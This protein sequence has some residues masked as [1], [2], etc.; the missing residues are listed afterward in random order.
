MI[1]A[2]E[3]IEAVLTQPLSPPADVSIALTELA[4]LLYPENNAISRPDAA[5]IA[6]IFERA[7]GLVAGLGAEADGEAMAQ[8]LLAIARYAYV[9]GQPFQGLPAIKRTVD[10]A[11]RLGR[12][13]L[14]CRA[15]SLHGAILMA[16]GDLAGATEVLANALEIAVELGDPLVQAKVFGN[17]GSLLL[18]MA[19]YDD[20]I[21]CTQQALSL[22]DSLPKDNG[23]VTSM[24]GLL[25]TNIA[26]ACIRVEDFERGLRAVRA[27]IQALCDPP[28]LNDILIRVAAEA[29]YVR[30]LLEVDDLPEARDRCKIAKGI[31]QESGLQNAVLIADMAEGVCEVHSGM[32]E[33]G[34][35]R[36]SK[37]LDRARVA[38]GLVLL[39]DALVDLIKANE[40]AG[41]HDVA[42]VYLRELMMHTKEVQQTNALLHHRLHL[43]E[44]EQ[45][46]R[47]AGC[48]D[49]LLQQ[50]EF[51][52]R[53]K[54]V[55]Q[56]AQQELLKSRVEILERLALQADLRSDTTGEHSYRVGKLAALLAQ[57]LGWDEDTVFLVE[58]AARLHDIGK[59]AIP[60]TTLLREGRLADAEKKL[61]ETHAL[62]GADILAQSNVP[63]MKMAEE[64][65]RFHHEYWDGGGYP[66]GLA[67]FAIPV[68][69]RITALADLFD[70]LTHRRAREET[71][72]VGQ[73]LAA[74]DAL[75]RKQFDPELTELFVA[76]VPRLQRE[77]GDLDKY[78]SQAALESPFIRARRKIDDALKQFQG[79]R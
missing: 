76:L 67:G 74:I 16:D 36:L 4:Q 70:E 34:L 23:E 11:S 9:S 25:L 13:A 7:V 1:D 39:Q 57:E 77:V 79:K 5:T 44:L 49:T 6:P 63:H 41:R 73:A 51:M 15:L 30:L 19:Q 28:T 58:L 64:I 61:T 17:V 54:L 42:L 8:C 24:R 3:P 2:L 43:K 33:V 75:K 71:L 52:L 65:A 68:A 55:Q 50:Q 21:L 27:A 18:C 29:N 60:E 20:G 14:S 10:L 59:I 46:E 22:S 62:I 26:H 38:K 31:A 12:R 47:P 72:S 32:V 45:N 37:S 78:L 35:S 56:V 69:A 66:F 48:P 53:G 40:F